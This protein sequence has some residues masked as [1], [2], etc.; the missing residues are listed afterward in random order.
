MSACVACA[1]DSFCLSGRIQVREEAVNIVHLLSE[2]FKGRVLA[3]I[4]KKII[5]V[6]FAA[7]SDGSN[8]VRVKLAL[9]L[10][11]CMDGWTYRN[12]K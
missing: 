11:R 10:Y 9:S 6:W 2:Q 1:L 5:G 12:M 8:E 7:Q 3:P 4:L